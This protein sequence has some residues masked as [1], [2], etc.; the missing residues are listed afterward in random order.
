MKNSS[1]PPGRGAKT[2]DDFRPAEQ[3]R[4]PGLPVGQIISI[5]IALLSAFLKKKK[6]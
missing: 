4:Q 5:I 1:R 2:A 6:S 3:K